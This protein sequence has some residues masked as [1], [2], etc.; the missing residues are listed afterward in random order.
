MLAE[1]A[2]GEGDWETEFEVA[3]VRYLL[4]V[5]LP[6]SSAML[7]NESRVLFCIKEED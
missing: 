7:D 4:P 5:G 1:G 2:T 3:S 6:L